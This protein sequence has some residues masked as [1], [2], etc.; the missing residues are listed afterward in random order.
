LAIAG[1][2]AAFTRLFRRHAA[3]VAGALYRIVGADLDLDAVV[4]ATFV[5]ARRDLVRLREPDHL[6]GWLMAIALRHLVEQ[7]NSKLDLQRYLPRELADLMWQGT[8][9]VWG[10]AASVVDQL[11]EAI[12]AMPKR[13]RVPFV[14]QRIGEVPVSTIAEL[15]GGSVRDVRRRV[16]AAENRL[17]RQNLAVIADRVRL[18][19]DVP[20]HDIREMRVLNDVRS[21]PVVRTGFAAIHE[22]P[23]ATGK[24]S[25]RDRIVRY[26][27][28][29]VC[30]AAVVGFG[31]WLGP[32]LQTVTG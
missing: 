6:R 31:A 1:N 21:V 29:A 2:D 28:L 10:A 7:V 11:R 3:F 22:A 8:P 19:A 17:R 9:V 4:A 32:L 27:A 16:W 12:A 15:C 13:L 5:E 26:G 23:L 14:L 30:S 20:W 18:D 24:P 25:V